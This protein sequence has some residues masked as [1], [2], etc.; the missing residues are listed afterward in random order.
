M[1]YQ[2]GSLGCFNFSCCTS[3]QLGQCQVKSQAAGNLQDGCLRTINEEVKGDVP[4]IHILYLYTH[5]YMYM[6][7]CTY[8]P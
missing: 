6:Y 1:K 4:R 8:M 3:V 7:I 2:T 5:I